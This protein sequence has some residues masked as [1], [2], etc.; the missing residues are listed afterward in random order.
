MRE[1]SVLHQTMARPK[2]YM[3]VDS[4]STPTDA[5]M[6][7]IKSTWWKFVPIYFPAGPP[8]NNPKNSSNM[9]ACSLVCSSK[10]YLDREEVSTT[11]PPIASPVMGE[12]V[13]TSP[14]LKFGDPV[15]EPT[16]EPSLFCL[17][18]LIV[19]T[20]LGATARAGF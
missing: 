4:G 8:P 14:S 2:P 5:T 10:K 17:H 3:R 18:F 11:V 15:I 1:D 6:Y 12:V 13:T 9:F 16:I 19:G 7:G 20:P